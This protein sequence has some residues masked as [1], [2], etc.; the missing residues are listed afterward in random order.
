MN[1]YIE[2]RMDLALS[3]KIKD[4]MKAYGKSLGRGFNS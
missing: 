4:I 1:A 2:N 3:T